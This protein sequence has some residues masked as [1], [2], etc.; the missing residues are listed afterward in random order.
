MEKNPKDRYQSAIGIKADLEQCQKMLKKIGKIDFFPLG[1]DDVLDHLN[2]SQKLYGRESESKI[3]LEAFD[4]A[5]QGAVEALM[6]SGYAGIGKSMLINEVRKPMVN[7]KVILLA[8][9]SIS[10]S[11]T[12]LIKGSHKP[13]M[14]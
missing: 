4:R 7:M 1:Q 13:S 3:L 2:L 6:I 10:F 14:N 9:N 11:S 5:S 12:C 8:E